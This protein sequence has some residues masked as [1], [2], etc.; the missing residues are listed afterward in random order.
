ML[1]CDDVLMLCAGMKPVPLYSEITEAALK[2]LCN[3][4]CH[5]VFRSVITRG[6]NC[7][8]L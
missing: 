4:S 6:N 2:I 8:V 7:S 5:D 1:N 3:V